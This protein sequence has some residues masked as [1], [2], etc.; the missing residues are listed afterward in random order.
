MRAPAFFLFSLGALG[1]G[2][3]SEIPFC[4]F[5]RG[6]DGLSGKYSDQLSVDSL[7]GPFGFFGLDC[8]LRYFDEANAL[9]RF[10]GLGSDWFGAK[11]GETRKGSPEGFAFID[12]ELVIVFFK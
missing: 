9:L 2:N 5:C 6:R 7:S 11:A 12:S 4:G 8:R 1:P 10:P 3:F